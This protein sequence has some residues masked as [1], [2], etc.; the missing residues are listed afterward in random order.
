MIKAIL[1]TIIFFTTFQQMFL[2]KGIFWPVVLLY[3]AVVSCSDMNDDD[4]FKWYDSS[5]PSTWTSR[6]LSSATS[7]SIITKILQH[8]KEIL[9]CQF[10]TGS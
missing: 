2:K 4:Y 5:S 10:R 7:I 3:L 8:S 6:S 1:T 9:D